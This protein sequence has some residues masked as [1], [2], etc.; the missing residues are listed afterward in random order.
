[1]RQRRRALRPAF[2]IGASLGHQHNASRTLLGVNLAQDIAIAY[3]AFAAGRYEEA[4]ARA[5]QILKQSPGEPAALTLAGRLA[6]AAGESDVAH[7]IF[8]NLLRAHANIPALWIDLALALRDLNHPQKA[9]EALQQA[10]ALDSRDSAY[11]V[12]LGEMQLS[13]NERDSA[14]QSFRRALDLDP[15]NVPAF[16]GLTQAE[17]LP[18]TDAL[19]ARFVALADKKELVPKLQAQ[20]HYTLAQVFKR[21]HMHDAFIAHLFAANTQQRA[22]CDG[23][24]ME[25]YREMFDRL[26]AAFDEIQFSELKRARI[27]TPTPIF[28]LG[29]PRSGTT[30]VERLL[31]AHPRV[32]AAGEIDYMRRVLRRSIERHTRRPFPEGFE[33]LRQ[34]IVDELAAAFGRRL[35]IMGQGADFVTDKTPGNYHLLGLLRVLFPDGRIVHV[36]RDPMDTCFSILQY[37]FD[38]RSPH[39]CDVDLLAYAYARYRSLMRRWEQLCGNEFLTVRY[40]DLVAAPLVHAPRMYAHCGLDWRDE[41]L[42]PQ[43][44]APAVRTFS[45]M[46]V[47]EPIHTRSVGAWREYEVELAPLRESLERAMNAV[48]A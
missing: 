40:E 29:M 43:A 38:D 47:R 25:R 17:A 21:A 7:D 35:Q 9:S 13:L 42:A 33:S 11:Y 1:M 10:I 39:T 37:P 30:L 20:L 19:V 3:A 2:F 6:L 27:I 26:E 41:F 16:R 23:D 44:A 31:A 14:S 45:V 28:I 36:E 5:Q 18:P 22:M 32:T 34:P 4:E 15:F 12:R 48:G 46:Q 8:R 24:A